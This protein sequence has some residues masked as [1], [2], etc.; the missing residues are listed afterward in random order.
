MF[1]KNNLDNLDLYQ[2]S[3][4]LDFK[5][6]THAFT[7][8]NLNFNKNILDNKVFEK[9]CSKICSKL[10]LK[11]LIICNQKHTNNI[12]IIKDN[13]EIR[14]FD[15]KYFDTIITNTSKIGIAVFTADCQPILL[16]DKRK[17]VI[18]AVHSGWRGTLHKIVIDTINK[19]ISKFGCNA[20]DIVCVIGP[21]IG[22]CHF[23][24][25]EDV[26]EMF[27]NEFGTMLDFS[28]IKNK[29]FIDTVK[30]NMDLLE[31][32][33]I[34]KKNIFTSEIC[35]V[36]RNDIFY[37]HRAEKEKAR[38]KSFYN[39]IKINKKVKGELLWAHI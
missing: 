7:Y 15:S 38:K 35:T 8:K 31:N 16:Y 21:S 1:I 33:G 26:W 13:K 11:E 30:L 24:V 22:K 3:K 27:V 14:N 32:I 17:K 25:N 39:S 36:C 9:N 12:L 5:D 4:F 29:Y 19:M 2:F 37:S 34:N 10:K 18:A 6:I 23:E 28:K 20:R